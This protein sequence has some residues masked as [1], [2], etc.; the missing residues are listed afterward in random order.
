VDDLL[1]GTQRRTYRFVYTGHIC[2]VYFRRHDLNFAVF[3][4]RIVRGF[5]RAAG[6]RHGSPVHYW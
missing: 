4:A 6:L 1:G 5:H 3:E 2:A